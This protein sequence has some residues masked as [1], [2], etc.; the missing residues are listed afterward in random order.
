MKSDVVISRP[1]GLVINL[2]GLE[3]QELIDLAKKILDALDWKAPE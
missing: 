1:D 3:Y 2:S